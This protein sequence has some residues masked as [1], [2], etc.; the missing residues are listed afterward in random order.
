MLSFC[1]ALTGCADLNRGVWFWN[2]NTSPYGSANIVGAPV[3]EAQTVDF[4][5]AHGVKRIYGSYKNRSIDE[6]AVIAAWNE[7][8]HLEG[9]QSQFLFA[10][11][12]WVELASR[13]NLLDK[14]TTRVIDFNTAPERSASEK[15][16]AVHLD[17][18]PQQLDAW[19][20]GSADVK[21]TY[22]TLLLDTYTEVRAH[23]D[24]A[25]Q[26]EIGVYADLPVWFD[27]LPEDGGSVGWADAADRDN[28][29]AA[30]GVPLSGAS[31]MTFSRNSFS[32]ID[33]AVEYERAHILGATVRTGIQPIIGADETWADIGDFNSMVNTL[34]TAY[35]SDSATDI[36]NYRLWREAIAAQPIT[37]VAT[38][39]SA[40]PPDLTFNTT[41]GGT[42]VVQ[43]SINL[44]NWQEIQ[45]VRA[46]EINS[47][48]NLPVSLD[49]DLGFWNIYRFEDLPEL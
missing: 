13:S 44:C 19:D 31:L 5:K 7:Q 35:G 9:I 23:L 27:K 6:P 25:G 17:I 32:S 14:I 16:D 33:L 36:E 4:L 12:T 41:T 15:F 21:R 37:A 42:Y 43:H 28:W 20:T 11:P 18:E 39:L 2:S 24:A 3:L 29:H 46:R 38:S 47:I 22:L 30:I 26:T 48:T 49:A 34:E 1:C 45:R 40:S 10:E 8:L